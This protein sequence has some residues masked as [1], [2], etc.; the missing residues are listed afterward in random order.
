[1]S[2]QGAI[3]SDTR[4]SPTKVM[5]AVPTK[6]M[7]YSHFAFCLQALVKYNASRGI[8]T[9]VEFDLGTLVC[10]Q[11]ERLTG[12]AVDMHATHIMWLD[13]DMMFP[14]NV[15]EILLSHDLPVVA[16]N[17]STRALPLKAVAYK[18]LNDWESG[19]DKELTGLELVDA[20]GLGCALTSTSVF[21]NSRKPWFPI[22]YDD[23]AD[24][25]LGED[26][27]FC[28]MVAAL[29]FPIFIDC[30]LSRQVYHIGSTAF[31]WNNSPVDSNTV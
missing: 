26:M 8:E 22:T 4:V 7:M 5:I 16:C 10:N 27:N 31:R 3:I 6:D 18:R 1:M 25:Y 2:V 14:K 21:I 24:D 13:S 20:V 17:Y 30:D 19:I 11:R 15:C 28:K 9:E 12:K 29:G 23:T